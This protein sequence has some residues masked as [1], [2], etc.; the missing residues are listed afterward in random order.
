MKK[1]VQY[2]DYFSISDHEPETIKVALIDLKKDVKKAINLLKKKNKT[3]Q[4]HVVFFAAHPVRTSELVPRAELHLYTDEELAKNIYR[5]CWKTT[6]KIPVA[7]N[8]YKFFDYCDIKD[9]E[10]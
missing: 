5:A 6:D 7:G 8:Y 2:G 9:L 4:G 10:D 1:F 3:M